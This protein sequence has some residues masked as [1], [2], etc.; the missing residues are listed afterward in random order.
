M[1]NGHQVAVE[2]AVS[3]TGCGMSDSKLE[4]MFREFEQVEA[5]VPKSSA[6]RL[7]MRFS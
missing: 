3:D 7:G 1:R 4:S 2:F 6:P 5:P